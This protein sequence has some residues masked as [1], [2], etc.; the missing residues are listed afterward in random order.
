MKKL[1]LSPTSNYEE[2][3]CV[4]RFCQFVIKD[5]HTFMFTA[6]RE[7]ISS[8]QRR[9]KCQFTFLISIK[10]KRP[11]FLD[12]LSLGKQMQD[13]FSKEGNDFSA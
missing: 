13:F 6:V 11:C 3:P 4:F 2:I 9:L 12:L 1:F 8:F 7:K 10:G 5:S